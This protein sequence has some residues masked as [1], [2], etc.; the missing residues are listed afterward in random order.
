MQITYSWEPFISYGQ[1][2]EI[3]KNTILYSQ[4]EIGNG[5][6]YLHEGE[7]QI[8]MLSDKGDERIIDYISPGEL[9]G[10][11]GVK[12][13][14]YFTTAKITKPSTIFFY[15]KEDLQTIC[16]KHSAASDIILNSLVKKVRLLAET[17]S[18]QDSSMEHQLAHIIYKLYRKT[19]NPCISIDQTSLSNYIGTSRVT[20]YKILQQWKE[21]EIVNITDRKIRIIN[22]NK[23][24]DLLY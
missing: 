13:E 9:L 5:F 23:F 8:K 20:I 19:Q 24:K 15:S 10:E 16:K 12:G 22:V 4:G 6:Y 7:I 18:I 2:K 3:K 11:Q 1:K 17:V 21:N 14:P